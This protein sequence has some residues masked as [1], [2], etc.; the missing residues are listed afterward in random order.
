[1]NYGGC[2]RKSEF[3]APEAQAMPS[4]LHA[5][6]WINGTAIPVRAWTGL[7]APAS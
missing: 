3:T 2:G 6:G 1:M 7:R 4:H 5:F